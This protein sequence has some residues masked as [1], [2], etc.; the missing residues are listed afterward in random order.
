M[1]SI[2]IEFDYSYDSSGFFS[3]PNAYRQ[4]ILQSAADTIASQLNGPLTAILPNPS[5]GHSWVVSTFNPSDSNQVLTLANLTI[6]AN[7]VLIFVGAQS[8]ASDIGQGAPG[9]SAAG[10]SDSTWA[11]IVQARGHPGALANPPTDFGPWGGSISF[12][13]TYP[14]W[15]FGLSSSGIQSDQV[16]FWSAAE[17]EIAHA[18]GFGTAPSWKAQLS[19]TYF[20]GA[21]VEREYGGPA[22]VN[23]PQAFGGD[24]AAGTLDHGQVANMDV[25]GFAGIRVPL[26]ALDFAGLY[27]VGWQPAGA[28]AD[29]IIAV[30]ADSGGIVNVYDAQTM[31]L[32]TSFMPFG[33][34]TGSVRVAVGDVNGDSIP[35]IICGAG[36]GG[37]PEVRVFDGKTFQKIRDFMALPT[38]FAGGVF[39]A[40]GDV[41]GD[42]YADI[43]TSADQGG[44]PQVTIT[45]G[46]DGTQLASFY[47]TAPTFTGGIRVACADINGT[48]FDDVIAAA[49]PGGGPQVTIF[50]GASLRLLTAFYALTPSFTGGLYVAAGDLNGDGRAEIIAGAEKGG[51]PQVAVFDGSTQAQITSFFALPEQFT[52]GVRVGFSSSVTGAPAILAVAG[53]GGGPQ[54]ALFDGQSYALRDSFFA[55]APTYAGGLFVAG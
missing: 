44:G 32:L 33:N 51:G 9:T 5:A 16:D 22:P 45:S 43:V 40:A 15:Y 11:A 52:G 37:A 39:V 31:A 17:H 21:H 4:A 29:K 10:G 42:G 23:L 1:P 25:Q 8:M 41:N 20:V 7:T 2:S 28:A 34:F 54:T 36:P 24:W 27:D 49:G 30:G 47:A 38:N 19:G 53:P 18:L 6:P 50:D 55:F 14:H 13:S 26:T 35:D 12:D 46:K 3:G 48:G